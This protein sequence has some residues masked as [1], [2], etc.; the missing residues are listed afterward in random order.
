M[1]R[2]M[3]NSSSLSTTGKQDI[4][5]DSGAFDPDKNN[6]LK[7]DGYFDA[8]KTTEAFEKKKSKADEWNMKEYK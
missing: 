4:K 3:F 1:G 2:N 7:S 6:T 5:Q 8:F